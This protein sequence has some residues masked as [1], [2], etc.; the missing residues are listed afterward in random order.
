MKKCHLRH[1]NIQLF[2]FSFIDSFSW[3]VNVFFICYLM[4][5]PLRHGDIH[6]ASVEP[7]MSWGPHTMTYWT[8][9]PLAVSRRGRCACPS[10]ARGRE[11]ETGFTPFDGP[12]APTPRGL[13]T[14]K[15]IAVSRAGYTW[16]LDWGEQVYRPHWVT[17]QMHQGTA[18]LGCRQLPPCPMLRHRRYTYP[19]PA[20]F[21]LAPKAAVVTG[22][23]RE[24]V[25]GLGSQ[26]TEN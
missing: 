9:S 3:P 18:T 24:G 14:A 7:H 11:V 25:G 13:M 4:S 21:M 22:Q 26:G 16:Q 8:H 2:F 15:C 17:Y 6:E 1:K 12:T 19:V 10:L 5:C 20:L 23:K